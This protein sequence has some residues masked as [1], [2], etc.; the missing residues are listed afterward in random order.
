MQSSAQCAHLD[1]PFTEDRRV[2][3]DRCGAVRADERP[4]GA[5]EMDTAAAD[6]GAVAKVTDHGENVAS[7]PALEANEVEEPVPGVGVRCNPQ[8]ELEEREI[9]DKELGKNQVLLA[10]RSPHVNG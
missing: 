3:D 1:R 8:P 9:R 4:L 10:F 6:E 7:G 2:G 5:P